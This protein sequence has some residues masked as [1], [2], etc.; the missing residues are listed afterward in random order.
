MANRQRPILSQNYK[1]WARP[2]TS[3]AAFCIFGGCFCGCAFKNE[4]DLAKTWARSGARRS[5]TK[6]AMLPC[7]SA[8]RQFC[9]PSSAFSRRRFAFSLMVRQ[10]G[11]KMDKFGEKTVEF[12]RK[13][14]VF[15]AKVHRFF[16]AVEGYEQKRLSMCEK[17]ALRGKKIASDVALCRRGGE[18]RACFCRKREQVATENL[19]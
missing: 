2:P 12:S 11:Q 15:R 10:I 4:R 14:A 1:F 17:S 19:L 13:A 3:A 9:L 7:A 8:F 6:R 5:P 16:G 18:E